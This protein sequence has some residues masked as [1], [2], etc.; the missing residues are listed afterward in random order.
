METTTQIPSLNLNL[1][2]T[3][4][5]NNF[6]LKI[7]SH[8]GSNNDIKYYQVT[9]KNTD[10]NK[11]NEPE[12][13]LGLLRVGSAEGGLKR[14]L[15]L[16]ELLGKHKMVSELLT[17]Q[18]S[19][20]FLSQNNHQEEL[21]GD[22]NN[23]EYIVNNNQ[24]SVDNLPNLESEISP[25][26]EINEAND[27]EKVEENSPDNQLVLAAEKD[28]GDDKENPDLQESLES[29]S[30]N[31]QIEKENE[32]E[33][34]EESQY[35]EEEYYE[36][37]PE[38]Y[39]GE[40]ILILTELP[41]P[42]E[43]LKSWLEKNTSLRESL[44]LV[45]QLTQFFRQVID[46][47]WCFVSLLPQFIKQSQQGNPIQFFD[48]T[49]IYP[50]GEKLDLGLIGDYYPPEISTGEEIREKMSTYVVGC[51]LYQALHH[52]LPPRY[53]D[54]LINLEKNLDLEIQ[55]IPLIYQILSI[56]LSP[57]FQNRFALSQLLDLL[58]STRKYY[59]TQSIRW[60]MSSRSTVGLSPSR[61]Q[62]EDNYGII[63]NCA[64]NEQPFILAVVADGMGGM[65]K[66]EVA[67]KSAVE[68]ILNSPIRAD[69]NTPQ[70]CSQWLTS[71]VW[72]ANKA[73]SAKVRNGG[74]TLSMVMAMEQKL[75]LAHVGDSR[76][77]LLRNGIICQLSEDHSVVAMLLATDQISY[78]E[79]LN[80]PD[81]NMLTKSLGSNPILPQNYVQ[82][83]SRFGED[84]FLNLEN[85]DIILLCSDGVWDLVNGAQLAE[86]FTNQDNLHLAVTQTMEQVIEKGA[87][88]NAT[89]IAL[90][91]HI[92]NNL[93]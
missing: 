61:L 78:E 13:T 8:L 70:K 49:T 39:Q 65:A 59:E 25:N 32:A 84:L 29:E 48:L 73:V 92:E 45:S 80:H 81:R 10:N 33:T 22:N 74:T 86:N 60:E 69:L 15:Q 1:Q 77:F 16:R 72:D 91:C 17:Y 27:L 43:T 31:Q 79:S 42:E 9:I 23:Q 4:Q 85:G 5:I 3:Y 34:S 26:L 82:N 64:S 30:N 58:I 40:K 41:T 11:D 67:S 76:V 55:K 7:D 54:Q 53:D 62:N 35:L 71:L 66:G 68:T 24:N 46:K 93:F 88:D 6:S 63:Q 83:L 56:S 75:Y 18:T 2:Q 12:E 20:E 87:H 89:L 14:E 28:L 21:I 52:Q 38:I 44:L 36:L 37:E 57:V 19:T 50:L 51:V 47:N 90:K